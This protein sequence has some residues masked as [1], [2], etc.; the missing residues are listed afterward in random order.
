MG[1]LG[2]GLSASK[3]KQMEEDRNPASKQLISAEHQDTYRQDAHN[4]HKVPYKHCNLASSDINPWL[5]IPFNHSQVEDIPFLELNFGD[6]TF[7]SAFLPK[8]SSTSQ[9]DPLIDRY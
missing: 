3:G 1:D 8:L 9:L 6:E 2:V 5:H 4:N 7:Q